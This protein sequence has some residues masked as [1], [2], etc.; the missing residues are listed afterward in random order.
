MKHKHQR[1][2]LISSVLIGFGLSIALMLIAFR[3]TMVFFYTPSDLLHKNISPKQ[4]LRIG[5]LVEISSV[6]QTAETVHFKITDQKDV[7]NVVYKGLL[8]DLFREGQGVVAEGYL[9]DPMNFQATT[10]LAKHDEKYMPK[11]VAER[12]KQTG[13]WRNAE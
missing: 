3:D 8:P 13:L 4:R 9:L 10:I 12:L 6:H 11:E 5:G 7:I 1:L 2:V